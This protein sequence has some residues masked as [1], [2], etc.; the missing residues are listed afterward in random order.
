MTREQAELK[1]EMLSIAKKLVKAN[2]KK[3]NQRVS[4]YTGREIS[5]LAKGVLAQHKK[6]ITKL[7]KKAIAER[8]LTPEK[9]DYIITTLRKARIK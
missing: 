4:S 1:I 2:I 8:E 5:E 7:A 6:I 3:E 9:I